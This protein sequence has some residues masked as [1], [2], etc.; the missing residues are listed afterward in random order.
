[1]TESPPSWRLPIV[2]DQPRALAAALRLDGYDPKAKFAGSNA[3]EWAVRLGSP[4]CLKRLAAMPGG[5]GSTASELLDLLSQ[6][7]PQVHRPN[8]EDHPHTSADVFKLLLAAGGD[9]NT[10]TVGD[11]TVGDRLFNDATAHWIPLLKEAGVTPHIKWLRLA[12]RGQHQA[13]RAL[14]EAFP[15]PAS[16]LDAVIPSLL[17]SSTAAARGET[18]DV[19]IAA[20]A[21]WPAHRNQD[22]LYFD[23]LT[24]QAKA[25]VLSRLPALDFPD[26]P[27]RNHWLRQ[28]ADTP[29]EVWSTW[30]KNRRWDTDQEGLPPNMWLPSMSPLAMRRLVQVGFD[31]ARPWKSEMDDVPRS[32][33]ERPGLL[34]PHW[35]V[36]SDPELKLPWP[37]SPE[38]PGRLKDLFC[39]AL[40]Q[41]SGDL[42]LATRMHDRL[43]PDYQP[44]WEEAL[45]HVWNVHLKKPSKD[46]N[47]SDLNVLFGWV[48]THAPHFW[49]RSNDPG[50]APW[51]R[52]V[53]PLFMAFPENQPWGHASFETAARQDI[54]DQ[55][56]WLARLLAYAVNTGTST[57][58]HGEWLKAVGRLDHPRGTMDPLPAASS[59]WRQE[60]LNV[61][62]AELRSLHALQDAPRG[63]RA[64]RRV[65][66]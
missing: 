13:L 3:A 44:L 5:W 1:M 40:L 46:L 37:F 29:D 53:W 24:D 58:A 22:D 31:P 10:P 43:G 11:W 16:D 27:S 15:P 25:T 30:T 66:P 51:P 26:A 45:D 9:V 39:L 23:G 50:K 14:I 56:P 47:A 6:T 42:S 28:F 17:V 60:E 61:L 8:M 59:F 20:G 36:L 41:S 34:L 54:Q 2:M 49:S 33:W 38:Q 18:L 63:E 65:R 52:R 55:G 35:D 19:L 48:D 4:Q 64:R 32:L 12:V 7:I 62:R 21:R 57:P